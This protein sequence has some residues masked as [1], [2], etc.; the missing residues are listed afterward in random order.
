LNA[1][2]IQFLDTGDTL[3]LTFNLNAIVPGEPF[4]V[5][6]VTF[7]IAGENEIVLGTAGDDLLDGSQFGDNITGGLGDDDIRGLGGKDSITG[8]SGDDSIDG[9]GG[10][11]TCY[12]KGFLN[13]PTSCETYIP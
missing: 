2:Q 7:V 1:S 4:G 13:W 8:D 3:R 12:G 5:Q 6:T 11:D 9:G 10:N